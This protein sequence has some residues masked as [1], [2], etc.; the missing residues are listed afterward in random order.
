MTASA[1][2]QKAPGSVISGLPYSIEFYDSYASSFVDKAL[3]VI[4]EVISRYER[5]AREELKNNEQWSSFSR[6]VNFKVDEET[7]SIY[8]SAPSEVEYGN[9][10]IPPSA[11]AR[12]YADKA[13]KDLPGLITKITRGGV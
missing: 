2:S 9:R 1:Y 13:E 8:F 4:D 6:E 5:A 10:D 7:S 3:A 12:K 11:V